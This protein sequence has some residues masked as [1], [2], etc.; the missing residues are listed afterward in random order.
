[1]CSH[2][3]FDKLA[4]YEYTP[5]RR[6]DHPLLHYKLQCLQFLASIFYRILSHC[7][8]AYLVDITIFKVWLPP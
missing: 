8:I 1:M 6:S 5:L 7:A 3:G 2:V 4:A